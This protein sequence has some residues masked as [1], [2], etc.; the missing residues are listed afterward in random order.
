[1]NKKKLNSTNANYEP[2]DV[3]VIATPCVDVIT[4]SSGP[5]DSNQG[6]WDKQ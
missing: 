2:P 4:T 6:E 3:E 5:Q 1:M